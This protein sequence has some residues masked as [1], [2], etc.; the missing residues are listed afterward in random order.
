MRTRDSQENYAA[1]NPAKFYLIDVYCL[2]CLQGGRAIMQKKH[3]AAAAL[4][5]KRSTG[6]TQWEHGSIDMY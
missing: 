3:L 5:K 2:L 4:H 1:L 6:K